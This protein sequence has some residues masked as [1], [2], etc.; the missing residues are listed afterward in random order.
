MINYEKVILDELFFI[1]FRLPD[2]VLQTINAEVEE[3]K[4]SEFKNAVPYNKNLAGTLEHEY[5]LFKCRDK[6]NN[7]FSDQERFN[8]NGRKL[9]LEG[10]I[11]KS[12]W[13]NF[14]QKYEHNPIHNH[15]GEFS[16]V[17]WLKIPYDL[18]DERKCKHARSGTSSPVSAFSFVY[19]RSVQVSRSPVCY[20]RIE[21]D[22]SWEGMCLL[23]PS[24]LQHMVTPFYTSDDYRISVSGNFSLVDAD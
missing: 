12:L 22:R 5:A 8:I 1:Q 15:D 20:Y 6:I 23:F 24:T 11:G 19:S 9:K 10:A 21:V 18:E 13:V 7:F 16:F 3:I 4:S 2:D 14:Q 17:T